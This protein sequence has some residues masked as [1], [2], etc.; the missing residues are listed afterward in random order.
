MDFDA[1]YD[2]DI[3]FE[4]SSYCSDGEYMGSKKAFKSLQ[5][6]R[7]AFEICV[8]EKQSMS[9]YA[10]Q[11]SFS[12]WYDHYEPEIQMMYDELSAACFYDYKGEKL[13]YEVPYEKFCESLYGSMPHEYNTKLGKKAPIFY[14]K[15]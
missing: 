13:P 10:G 14:Q 9:D 6:E 7:E 4:T 8:D 15:Y 11:S 3:D 2:L 5:Q 12:M 1:D